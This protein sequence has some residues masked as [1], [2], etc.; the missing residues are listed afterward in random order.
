MNQIQLQENPKCKDE[1]KEE[2][3]KKGREVEKGRKRVIKT[4][5]R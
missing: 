5:E 4:H 1:W 3:K 2:E